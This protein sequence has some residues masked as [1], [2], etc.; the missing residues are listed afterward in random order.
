MVLLGAIDLAEE[1]ES[2][3]DDGLIETAPVIS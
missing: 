2:E 1:P 3:F